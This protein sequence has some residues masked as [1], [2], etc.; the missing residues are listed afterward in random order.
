[1][2]C[3]VHTV[4]HGKNNIIH[5]AIDARLVF[6]AYFIFTLMI[7]VTMP[8]NWLVDSSTF[9]GF[10]ISSYMFAMCKH[11]YLF[12][13]SKNNDDPTNKMFCMAFP[14]PVIVL[15]ACHQ[16]FFQKRWTIPPILQYGVQ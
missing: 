7:S 3:L 6:T 4:V 9:P 11:T 1:M 16:F 10:G 8:F 2:V 5:A 12:L 15:H 13:T 14:W